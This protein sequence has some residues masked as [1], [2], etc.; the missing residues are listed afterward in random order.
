MA[1]TS[2]TPR[3]RSG[4][5]AARSTGGSRSTG[6]PRRTSMARPDRDGDATM[7]RLASASL[8]VLIAAAAAAGAATRSA[9]KPAQPAPS[10]PKKPAVERSFPSVSPDGSR[11]VYLSNETGDTDVYVMPA[12]GGKGVRLTRDDE[13]EDDPTWSADGQHLVFGD[14][15][16][17]G[18]H[19]FSMAPDGSDRRQIS[20]VPGRTPRLSPDGTRVAY[21][22]G[23]W[24]QVAVYVAPLAGGAT[25]QLTDGSGVAWNCEWSPDGH[26]LAFTGRDARG[27]L[28]IFVVD[29]DGKTP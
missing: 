9:V 12:A 22:R 16:R 11:I 10:A 27:N 29:A 17:E 21:S 14:A 3:R 25:I 24:T 13:E 2:A 8:V 6:G 15:D 4:C 28:Q 19:L 5:R 26:A 23:P 7:R 18:S 20:T 1:A